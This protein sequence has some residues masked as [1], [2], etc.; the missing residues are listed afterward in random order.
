[1]MVGEPIME[2]AGRVMLGL[3]VEAVGL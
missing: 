3:D 2:L 1:M